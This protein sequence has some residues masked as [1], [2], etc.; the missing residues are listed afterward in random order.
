MGGA[1][2]LAL[3]NVI[4]AFA[5]GEGGEAAEQGGKSAE[6]YDRHTSNVE[7]ARDRVNELKEE[8]GRAKGPKAQRPIRDQIERLTKAIKGHEKE[9]R[10][11]WPEGRPE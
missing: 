7:R 9:I 10:Q 8:L 3:A 4:H 2:G 1:A 6:E 11:K 5:S